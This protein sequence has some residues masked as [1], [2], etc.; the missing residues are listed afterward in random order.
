MHKVKSTKAR[1]EFKKRFGQSNH[2]LITSLIGLNEIEKHPNIQKPTEFSTSWQ[3]HDPI[4]SARRSRDF[5]LDSFLSHAVD[6]IDMYL[7]FLNKSPKPLS[8]SDF[9]L[10]FE[11]AQ[12]SV[13]KKVLGIQSL[14][15]ID[16]TI[17]GLV[18]LLITWRNNLTH[19]FA[20]NELSS[21][22]ET[23]LCQKKDYIL[24][25]FCSLKIE[26]VINKAHTGSTLNFKEVASLIK[27][28]HKFV[29]LV[30]GEILKQIDFKEYANDIIDY[31]FKQNKLS[32]SKYCIL[33]KEAKYR[34]VFNVLQNIGGFEPDDFI[35][36]NNLV[37]Q[38]KLAPGFTKVFLS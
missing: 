27:A 10:I 21:D 28:T 8:N 4:R 19:Y 16:Q 32:K 24:A 14:F 37:I 25:N 6:G 31:H 35:I 7:S 33:E 9:E 15:K 26:D 18:L 3:P 34:F 17:T 30:D 23:I 29:E 2:F 38:D 5:I 36:L 22:Y 13:F 11:K 1:K 12:Q 20:E